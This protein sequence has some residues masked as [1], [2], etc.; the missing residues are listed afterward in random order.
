MKHRSKVDL[1]NYRLQ[2]SRE[3]SKEAENSCS[4]DELHL[5]EN[6]IYYAIFYMAQALSVIHGFST[7]KHSALKG[8]FNK[9][10]VSKGVIEAKYSKIYNEAFEK[11]M[12]GDYDDFIVFEKEEVKE[13]ITA[14]KEFLAVIGDFI[15]KQMLEKKDDKS[16]S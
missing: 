14:M 9:E 4:H 8:W 12:E 6:R 10:F 2:R 16:F 3:T 5:A 1:V 13:D 15:Q 7:S 11:R